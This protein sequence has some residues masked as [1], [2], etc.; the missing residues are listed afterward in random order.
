MK[1]FKVQYI[2][3]SQTHETL[4]N[5][6]NRQQ[7]ENHVRSE[8]LEDEERTQIQIIGIWEV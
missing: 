5:A 8:M 2:K 4:T 6:E 1:Y 7:A 3:N